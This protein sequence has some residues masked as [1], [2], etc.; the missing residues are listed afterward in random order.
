M[1]CCSR[2]M[3]T[4]EVIL[5]ST[6]E[7]IISYIVFGFFA[8]CAN[9]SQC[10][11]IIFQILIYNTSRKR[12]LKK[13]R[14]EQSFIDR[15]TMHYTLQYAEKYR[16]ELLFWLRIKKSYVIFSCITFFIVIILLCTSK[17][18]ALENFI[19]VQ[20]IIE[21]VILIL[22]RLQF[23]VEGRTTRYEK[24]RLNKHKH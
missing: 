1:D 4:M 9:Y 11:E 20:T 16:K 21:L 6:K 3:E 7:L 13:I 5:M 17:V 10:R 14:K 8:K 24:E 2:F 19:I 15:I 23:G 18:S 22:L 12:A